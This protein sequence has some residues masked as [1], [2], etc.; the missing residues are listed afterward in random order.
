M[1]APCPIAVAVPLRDEA[2][3]VAA[4]VASL[5]AQ[6]DVPPFTL[7]LLFDNCTDD[8]EAVARAAAARAGLRLVAARMDDGAP[9]SAGRARATAMS[10]ALPHA[11]GGLLLTTDADSVPAPGWVAATVEGLA[12]AELVFGRVRRAG[13]PAPLQDRVERYYDGLHSLRR[14]LDPVLWEDALTHHASGAASL[15]IRADSYRALGGFPALG[16]GEDAALADAAARA[17]LRVR[18]D[19]RAEVV[20]S[21]R[22]HGRAA[23]GMAAGLAAHDAGVLPYVAHP[24]DEAWRYRRHARARA[25]HERGAVA[26]LAAA[27]GEAPERLSSLAA[28]CPNGEAFAARSVIDPPGGMRHV[29][30][31][32]AERA[33]AGLDAPALEGAA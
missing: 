25:A 11:A 18:R 13:P 16:S 23:G 9:P 24:A 7:C 1:T 10:L 12:R 27:W 32:I 21:A 6:A 26:A 3:G 4:L 14:R 33:L 28:D 8:S 31:G 17:G 30:L 2:D 15:G 22:R 19:A 29:P 5:A 20:T